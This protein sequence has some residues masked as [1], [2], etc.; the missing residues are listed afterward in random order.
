MQ[1]PVMTVNKRFCPNLKL[2]DY[3]KSKASRSQDSA[4]MMCLYSAIINSPSDKNS[5]SLLAYM[6]G[7]GDY[8]RFCYPLKRKLK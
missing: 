2:Y 3:F 6:T 7:V 8:D 5:K 1:N 4:F